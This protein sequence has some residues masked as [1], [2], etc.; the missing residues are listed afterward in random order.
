MMVLMNSAMMPQP[1]RYQIDQVEPEMFATL[2]RECE[3][4]SYIGYEQTAGFLSQ[5]IGRQVTVNRCQTILNDGDILFICKLKYRLPD[6]SQKGS[7][8]N[9]EN[10]EFFIATYER[11]GNGINI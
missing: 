4:V 5:L 1:G 7:Q 11:F 10:F 8:I 3:F 9:P 2:L 6:P